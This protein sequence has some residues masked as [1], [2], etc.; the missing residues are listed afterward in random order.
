VTILADECCPTYLV[1]SLREDGHDVQYIA[2]IA[3]STAD[4]DI[5]ETSLNQQRILLTEDRDFCELIFLNNRPAYA[6]VLLRIHVLKRIER[7]NRARDAFRS[8]PSEMVGKM[9]TVTLTI[10]RIPFPSLSNL[11]PEILPG[12]RPRW[13]PG[14]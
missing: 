14:A 2:E 1:E 11:P 12:C 10:P 13:L 9:T 8:L 6:V 4:S 5:L 7:I 3:P